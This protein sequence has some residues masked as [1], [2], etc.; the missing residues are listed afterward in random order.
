LD[1]LLL[2]VAVAVQK[3]TVPL[4]FAQVDQVVAVE[5][6]TVQPQQS[7]VVQVLQAKEPQEDPSYMHHHI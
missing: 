7:E 2:T 1:K 3:R 6:Q 4:V 5:R